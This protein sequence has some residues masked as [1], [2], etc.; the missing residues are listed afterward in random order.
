MLPK[1]NGHNFDV[2][3]GKVK[4]VKFTQGQAMKAQKVV[5]VYSYSCNLGARWGGWSIPH[6]TR[7]QYSEAKWSSC[8][9]V[10]NRGKFGKILN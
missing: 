10:K 4:K 9:G 5:G 7:Q 1:K 3:S 2:I 8:R 6:P